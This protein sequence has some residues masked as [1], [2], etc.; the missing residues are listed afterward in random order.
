M[1]TFKSG[2]PG[3]QNQNKRDTGV[4]IKHAPSGAVGES[5]EERTQG[6]NKKRAFERMAR[7]DAFQRWAKFTVLGVLDEVHKN[8]R[9]RMKQFENLSTEEIETYLRT[10]VVPKEKI[11]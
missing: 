11:K 4:R 3:G 8:V 6:L 7:S 5:R 1:Q 9:Q 2:G 10:G